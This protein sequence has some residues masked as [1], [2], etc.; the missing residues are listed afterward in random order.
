MISIPPTAIAHI[1]QLLAAAMDDAE[2][3]LRSPTSDPLRDMTLFRHRLRAVNRYMQD[4]LVAAKLHPKGDANMYQTVEFLHEME[5]KLAQAD[6][7]L[8]EFTLVVESRPVKVLD[9]HPSALAT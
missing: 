4:A 8:L 3:A 9:F 7:I 5:G 6:S 2:T 1:S